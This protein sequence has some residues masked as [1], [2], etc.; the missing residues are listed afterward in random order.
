ME[1]VS[2]DSTSQYSGAGV[3]MDPGSYNGD[4]SQYVQIKREPGVDDDKMDPSI[5]IKEA[6]PPTKEAR[7][8]T[9]EVTPTIKE[10][11]PHIKEE[12][13]CHTKEETLDG[14]KEETDT[15]V[16]EETCCQT[17][18]E[19]YATIQ[20]TINRVKQEVTIKLKTIK[21]TVD[22]RGLKRVG[23]PLPT[24]AKKRPRTEGDVQEK[25]VKRSGG[26]LQ[27]IAKKR[28]RVEDEV[29]QRDA[30]RERAPAEEDRMAVQ[31]I[32]DEI[33]TL[34]VDIK[35]NAIA[36]QECRKI[37]GMGVVSIK[38]SE[39]VDRMS[40]LMAKLKSMKISRREAIKKR[41]THI[42]SLFM[43]EEK[44][45][46]LEEVREKRAKRRRL[47][48]RDKEVFTEDQEA[49]I[50]FE[51][52]VSDKPIVRSNS[53]NC[54]GKCL[55]IV[56]DIRECVQVCKDC[57][58]IYE[59]IRNDNE[60]P[61]C[62]APKFGEQIDMPKR[63][64]GGYKPPTHF[65]EIV[66][67]FQGNRSSLTPTDIIDKI[68]WYCKRYY[69]KDH[70]ITPQ[71]ARFFLRRM[72]QEENNRHANAKHK[73]PKDKLRRFTD[74]YK[75]APEISYRLSGIPPPY[76][77][78][79]QEDR[80]MSLFP[81]VIAAY[82]MCP[83]YK[84]RLEKKREEPKERPNGKPEKTP[85]NPNYLFVFY[86]LCQLL[87]YDEFLPYI[88][89]PKNT[90]NIDDNDEHAWSYICKKYNWQYIPTR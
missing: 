44:A 80:V 24:S 89:L 32:D 18:Q 27:D 57:G 49:A 65:A 3:N 43:G 64:S 52:K 12:V 51:K 85:N 17:K 68:K 58:H 71:V 60:N 61:L 26:P 15:L 36:Y 66:G 81:Y 34:E 46:V 33:S 1:D 6:R 9:K 83:R 29:Q 41:D 90:D 38:A 69:Y 11:K 20:D 5:F 87:T 76:M 13:R 72:Q 28:P 75:H 16:K 23:D 37:M 88:P 30:K 35:N 25:G 31:S 86:K 48:P 55:N 22:Q 53:A 10:T 62:S 45:M 8:P 2:R 54:P 19:E 4:Y 21:L 84:T 67:H 74:Y 59:D 40:E 56:D 7:L 73:D 39:Q 14:I 63:R 82:K 79:M 42:A 78:P 47:Y 77:T 50:A 70:E